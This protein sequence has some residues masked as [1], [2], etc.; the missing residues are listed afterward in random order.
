MKRYHSHCGD[1]EQWAREE[2]GVGT[3][4]AKDRDG[5][6]EWSRRR[7]PGRGQIMGLLVRAVTDGGSG[8]HWPRAPGLGRGEW[9]QIPI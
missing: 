5:R 2:K 6:A 9:G 1:K 4:A 8:S 7:E 3:T